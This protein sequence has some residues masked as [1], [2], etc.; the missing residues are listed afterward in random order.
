MCKGFQA[1]LD[2]LEA[3]QAQQRA[4]EQVNMEGLRDLADDFNVRDA[5][6][7]PTCEAATLT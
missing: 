4:E 3:C 1:R 7:V 2:E 5:E 6:A